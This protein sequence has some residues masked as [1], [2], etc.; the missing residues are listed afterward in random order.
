MISDYTQSVL[1]RGEKSGEEK[2]QLNLDP[3]PQTKPI[4]FH[5][6]LVRFGWPTL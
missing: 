3:I 5:R 1:K 2:T 6:Y 4:I